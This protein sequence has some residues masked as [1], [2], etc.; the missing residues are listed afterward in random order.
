MTCGGTAQHCRGHSTIPALLPFLLVPHNTLTKA[1]TPAILLTHIPTCP[2]CSILSEAA[3]RELWAS[4]ALLRART[5]EW[6]RDTALMLRPMTLSGDAFWDNAQARQGRGGVARVELS[7][8]GWVR[9]MG[10]VRSCGGGV[11]RGPMTQSGGVS[12]DNMVRRCS[13][14]SCAVE[15]RGWRGVGLGAAATCWWLWGRPTSAKPQ[16]ALHA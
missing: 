3:P 6:V 8:W 12:W 9:G 16:A 4:H 11:R 13:A 5:L 14:R 15:V 2:P 10:R 1:S 7:A